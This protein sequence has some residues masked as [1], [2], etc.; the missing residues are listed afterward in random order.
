MSTP[1]SHAVA[2]A[3]LRRKLAE[4]LAAEGLLSDP[5]WRAA[6]RA[7]PRHA[8]TPGFYLQAGAA[9]DGLPVWEPVTAATDPD[10][11]LRTVYTDTTLVTQFDGD[12]PDWEHPAPRTGG[13]PTSS[14]TLPSL[15]LRMWLDAEL[16]PGHDVLEIGTGT[17]YSTAL[18]CQWLGDEGDIVSLEV[19]PRRAA[20][21]AEA[22]YGC[23][24]R[25]GLAVA[26]GLYGYWPYAPY[27][28]IVAACS[29]RSIPAGW[30]AQ[31]RPGGKILSTLSGWLNGSARALLTVADP[32]AG[33]AEG[34]LLDGTISFMLAR[35]HLPPAPGSPGHWQGLLDGPPRLARHAP[36]RIT[37]TDEATFFARFLAQLAAPH[38]VMSTVGDTVY[39]T[40]PVTGSAASLTPQGGDWVVRQ[41]G[42]A[43]LWDA[44]EAALDAWDAAGEPGPGHF[45]VRVEPDR[46]EVYL[47]GVPALAFR[48][49]Q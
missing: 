38:A 14:S 42:R 12:E 48:L 47:P 41:G 43:A 31:S 49:P 13:T 46:Q 10:R 2:A 36:A 5:G 21:A 15:V 22:L 1:T 26:D 29:V 17:G 34:P 28:R 4:E 23:G 9:E 11:W 32:V 6:A 8:F 33:T 16:R 35:T 3:P 45:R 39:F 19:D 7:V 37:P 30:I 27:D 24:Y 25:P 44:I 40:D 20:Q 18:A